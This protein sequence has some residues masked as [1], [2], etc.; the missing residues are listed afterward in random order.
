MV[1][2]I[3][4]RPGAIVEVLSFL[5][6]EGINIKD[7][8]ILRI[9]EGDGGTLKLSLEDSVAVDRAVV[10]LERHGFKVWKR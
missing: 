9:R 3:E 7:I 2:T 5:G 10:V 1:V 6:T 8:E 4:D